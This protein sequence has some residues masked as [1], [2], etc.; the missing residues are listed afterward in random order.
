M[1]YIVPLWKEDFLQKLLTERNLPI[2]H[3]TGYAFVAHKIVS[4]S[5]N[6]RSINCDQKC[7]LTFFYHGFKNQ[8]RELTEPPRVWNAREAFMEQVLLLSFVK[9]AQKDTSIVYCGDSDIGS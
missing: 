3:E 8:M 2:S 5:H 9:L 1:E 6:I 4:L 7:D